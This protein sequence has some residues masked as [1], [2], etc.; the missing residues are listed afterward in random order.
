MRS[1][2]HRLPA[3][4]AAVA[5]P[6]LVLAGCSEKTSGN[7]S[8]TG[9]STAAPTSGSPT[10]STSTKPS[11]SRPKVID[12]KGADPCG[13]LTDAQKQTFGLTRTPQ[14]LKSSGH[15]DATA[16][17][18]SSGDFSYG[19]S[20]VATPNEGIELYAGR[21]TT[22]P[23]QIAGF[24]ALLDKPQG[25]G[26]VCFLGV[27]VADGQLLDLQV[28]SSKIPVDELCTRAVAIGE[29]MIQTIAS[30]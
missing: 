5:I 15:K 23:V 3:L 1:Y 18:I 19:I 8:G 7:A 27:D 13:L 30:R 14:T 21:P 11:V 6:V 10:P 2:W 4:L 22:S 16:C 29:A 20:V 12:F 25:M 28:D 26:N 24:P 9:G 17:S